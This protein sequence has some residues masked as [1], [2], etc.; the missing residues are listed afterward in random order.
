MAE[1]QS[2]SGTVA[3]SPGKKNLPWLIPV[4]SPGEMQLP[5]QRNSP[6]EMQLP[7][8][9]NSVAVAMIEEQS[10]WDGDAAAMAEEQSR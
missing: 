1:E 9:R 3:N 7:W 5:W 6:G 4:N 10:S 2:R 8:K